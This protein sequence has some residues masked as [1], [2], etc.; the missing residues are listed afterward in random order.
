[1]RASLPISTRGR[2]RSTPRKIVLAA[3]AGSV[4]AMEP[5]KDSTTSEWSRVVA[6]RAVR[7]IEVLIL[8]ETHKSQLFA[9]DEEAS[10]GGATR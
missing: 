6:T 2:R 10:P 4:L 5:S 7:A 1:M 8:R 3:A 9:G